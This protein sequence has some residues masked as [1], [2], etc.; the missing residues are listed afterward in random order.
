[1]GLRPMKPMNLIRLINLMRPIAG[2]ER[3]YGSD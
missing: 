3:A 1:M 2:R